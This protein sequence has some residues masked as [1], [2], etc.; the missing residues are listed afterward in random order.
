MAL[1]ERKPEAGEL[2]GEP[3]QRDAG[4]AE[5]VGTLAFALDMVADMADDTVLSE[6]EAPPIGP[7]RRAE[8]ELVRAGVIGDELGCADLRELLL[9]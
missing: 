4:I 7:R 3:G 1:G 9:A 5:D 6:I 2:V 8:N